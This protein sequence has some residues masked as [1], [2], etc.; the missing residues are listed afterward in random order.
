MKADKSNTTV[1]MDK[2]KY[3][4]EATLMLSDKKTYV[5]LKKD[6]TNTIHNKVN[7]VIKLW[8]DKNYISK[9][10]TNSLKSSNPL[11]DRFYGLPKIH[12]MNFPL[13]PIVSFWA[14][15]LTISH[16]STTTLF[17]II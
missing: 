8:K 4:Q 13:R 3:I 1:A 5:P 7:N 9:I 11:P 2:N 6:P 12:K 10:T 17:Q 14:A 16:L 15:P